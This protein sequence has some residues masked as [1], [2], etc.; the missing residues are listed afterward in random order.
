MKLAIGSIFLAILLAITNVSAQKDIGQQPYDPSKYQGDINLPKASKRAGILRTSRWTNGIIPYELSSY[1]GQSH[2]GLFAAAIKE[3][4]DHSCIKFVPRT[5]EKPYL[6]IEN[7][8]G[9][10]SY[11]GMPGPNGISVTSLQDPACW[12]HRTIVH[13]MM[14]AIGLW[15]EHQRYDRDQFVTIHPENMHYP[16]SHPIVPQ[17]QSDTYGVPYNYLSVMHYARGSGSK[18]GMP[19]IEAKD[20]RYQIL[21]G[22]YSETGAETDYESIRRI[23]ECKESYPVMPP[24]PCKDTIPNCVDNMSQCKYEWGQCR[25]RRSC[26][27]CKDD[28]KDEMACC[29]AYAQDCNTKAWMKTVC[30]F[31]CGVCMPY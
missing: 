6:K 26:G 3:I 21:M 27:I 25:C 28:C 12:N 16:A 24:P 19:A 18:N 11:I 13:E 4:Q 29:S 14:H 5:T 2:K 17:N 23:Y 31:T 15:H 30:P 20:P 22:W 10:N 7:N 8:G 1:F 9:C